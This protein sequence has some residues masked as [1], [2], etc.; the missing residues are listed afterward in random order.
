M[1]YIKFDELKTMLDGVSKDEMIEMLYEKTRFENIK[2]MKVY[3][4]DIQKNANLR[5]QRE[6]LNEMDK[7]GDCETDDYAEWL[8]HQMELS[9][10]NNR[11]EILSKKYAKL[12]IKREKLLK[13][14]LDL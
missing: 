9:R 3:I 7:H 1:D 12:D 14:D 8:E 5:Q 4:I 13:I 2:D 11:F 6:V 10:L